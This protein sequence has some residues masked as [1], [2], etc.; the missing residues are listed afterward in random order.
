[1]FSENVEK[2]L[3]CACNWIFMFKKNFLYYECSGKL[4]ESNTLRKD[5]IKIWCNKCEKLYCF[6]N[7]RC[8]K[9]YE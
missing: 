9:S 7:E 2:F 8:I 5:N 4:L 3:V 6:L 1:M